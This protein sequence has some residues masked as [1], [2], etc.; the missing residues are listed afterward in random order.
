V[1]L[2]LD[3][4]ALYW[5]VGDDPR[6][7]E[8]AR[9]A[10]LASERVAVSTA[11]IWELAIKLAIG[12]LRFDLERFLRAVAADGFERLAILDRH[13]LRCAALPLHHRDPFDRMLVAQAVEEGLVLVSSNGRM[14]LYQ[15]AGLRLMPCG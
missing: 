7:G 9:A 12:K 10:I 11:S 14:P 1:S 4:Q 13:C 2:L 15:E 5:W 8:R 6:L 3:T